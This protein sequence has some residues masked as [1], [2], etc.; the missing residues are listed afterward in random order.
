MR[1]GWWVGVSPTPGVKSL[2]KG[3]GGTTIGA[4][5]VHWITGGNGIT[6]TLSSL[7]EYS[8]RAG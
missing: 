6:G 5:N 7:A 2:V 3:F 1:L 8:R 4:C